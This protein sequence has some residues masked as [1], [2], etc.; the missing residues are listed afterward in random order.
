MQ[1]DIMFYSNNCLFSKNV[2]DKT[3]NS[4]LAEYIEYVCIDNNDVEIPPF[5]NVVPTLLL[6]RDKK[7]LTDNT[8]DEWIGMN[9]NHFA[10]ANANANANTNAN[11]NRNSNHNVNHNPN[12]TPNPN[13]N[14][15]LDAQINDIIP[16][17]KDGNCGS[18]LDGSEG[19]YDNIEQL[20]STMNVN[21]LRPSNSNNDNKASRRNEFDRKLEELQQMRH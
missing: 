12:P 9:L 18:F 6:I 11:A 3:Y 2:I 14:A 20:F 4:P 16:Y 19:N 7:I 5:I 21:E 8:L 1:K 15:D 17:C 10:N 13:V